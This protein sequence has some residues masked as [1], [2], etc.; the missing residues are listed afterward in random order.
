MHT[1]HSL[2]NKLHE[3][4]VITVEDYQMHI[5]VKF[6]ENPNLLAYSTNK[7]LYALY[8]ICV[9]YLEDG[10]MKKSAVTFISSD[11]KH[12]HEQIQKFH[13]CLFETISENVYPGIKNW[14]CFS[15]DCSAQFKSQHCLVD[16]FNNIGL[17]KLMQASF[18]NFELHK[19]KN[20]SNDI[21]SENKCHFCCAMLKNLNI[22]THTAD[23]IVNAIKSE[24]KDK[25]ENIGFCII[26]SFPEFERKENR[27]AA[28]QWNKTTP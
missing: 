26:E 18:H 15:N 12:D 1:H 20:S 6:T 14:A 7:L 27:W 28:N 24:M 16:L 13:Q 4:S 9:E 10:I 8:P 3:W 25:T 11:K 21:G 23:D 19:G 22:T 5:E 17:L 2:Q